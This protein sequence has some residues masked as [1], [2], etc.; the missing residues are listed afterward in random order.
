MASALLY[1]VA[2]L[3]EQTAA[4][5]S[6]FRSLAALSLARPPVLPIGHVPL[7]NIQEAEFV[8]KVYIGSPPRPYT[9]VFDTGSANLWVLSKE[10]THVPIGKGAYVHD[11]SSTYQPNG[12]VRGLCSPSLS[13]SLHPSLA[14]CFSEKACTHGN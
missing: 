12:K 5:T 10:G 3:S 4:I 8:G 9:V 2:H 7:E 1:V 13:P 6:R 14:A 11:R